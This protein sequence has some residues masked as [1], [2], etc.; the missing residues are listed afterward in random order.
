VTEEECPICNSVGQ[1]IP[2][3]SHKPFSR[4]K[5]TL[6]MRCSRH[7]YLLVG[8]HTDKQNVLVLPGPTLVTEK[9]V[10]GADESWLPDVELICQE[11]CV[12]LVHPDNG[13]LSLSHSGLQCILGGGVSNNLVSDQF[14]PQMLVVYENGLQQQ[15]TLEEAMEYEKSLEAMEYEESLE[16]REDELIEDYEN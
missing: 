12:D 2:L 8:E 3:S 16:S 7:V 1:E 5:A 9:E 11:I 15:T 13:Q 10:L 4:G 6:C 14:V